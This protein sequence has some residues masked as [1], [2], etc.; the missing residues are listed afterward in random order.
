MDRMAKTAQIHSLT[1]M[2][3]TRV[4]EG[5]FRV[6]AQAVRRAFDVGGRVGCRGRL[7]KWCVTLPR[8]NPDGRQP[9]GERDPNHLG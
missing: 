3:L 1:S 7:E 8:A 9:A 6:N 5:M 2:L 4:V